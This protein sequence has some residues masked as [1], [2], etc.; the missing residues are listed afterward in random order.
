LGSYHAAGV[1][2][3]GL[4]YAAQ[5]N[6]TTAVRLV[7]TAITELREIGFHLYATVLLSGLA[8]IL[9]GSGKIDD[10]MAAADEAVTRAESGN[11]H[12]WLPEALRVKGEV[13]L[14]ASPEDSTLAE[15]LFG[16]AL[17]LAHRQGALSWEL[18]AATGLARFLRHQGRPADAV[19]LLQPI[20]ERFTEGFGTTDLTRARAL[21]DDL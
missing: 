13:A 16:C 1:G 3:E 14:L 15:D 17:D 19:A 9:A 2:F 7:R 8:E 21:L 18:R 5:G 11:N 12:W 20:Y 10:A 4:L 6:R